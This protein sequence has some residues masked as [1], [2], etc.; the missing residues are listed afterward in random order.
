M[1]QAPLLPCLCV[2]VFFFCSEGGSGSRWWSCLPRQVHLQQV[3]GFWRRPRESFTVHKIDLLLSFWRFNSHL[4]T[5]RIISVSLCERRLLL[6]SASV[7]PSRRQQIDSPVEPQWQTNCSPWQNSKGR[8]NSAPA[9]QAG[10][11][12]VVRCHRK[13]ANKQNLAT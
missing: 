4:I 3:F 10:G 5:V 8:P 13:Q 2:F 6:A 11:I 12:L 9:G 1:Q 7:S